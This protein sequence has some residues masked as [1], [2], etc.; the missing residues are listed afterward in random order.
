MTRRPG[1]S[2]ASATGTDPDS[3]EILKLYQPIQQDQSRSG[4]IL[5]SDGGQPPRPLNLESR[6]SC[7]SLTPSFRISNWRMPSTIRSM[8]ICPATLPNWATCWATST[9]P[10]QMPST[11]QTPDTLAHPPS[12]GGTPWLYND[13]SSNKPHDLHDHLPCPGRD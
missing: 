12:R 3:E 7:V 6:I 10:W 2:G 11:G 1:A 4:I 13:F 9:T 5:S 8:R